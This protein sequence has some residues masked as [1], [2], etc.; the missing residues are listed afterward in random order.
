MSPSAVP[1]PPCTYGIDFT[2]LSV[3]LT[4]DL[5]VEVTQIRLRFLVDAP[6]VEIQIPDL[7]AV[8]HP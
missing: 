1:Q 3:N 2:R 7:T 8:F 6:M 4:S 5:Q